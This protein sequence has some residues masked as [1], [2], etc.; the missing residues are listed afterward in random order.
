MRNEKVLQRATLVGPL[1]RQLASFA[2]AIIC[3]CGG[4]AFT[5]LGERDPLSTF[6][7]KEKSS[8]VERLADGRGLEDASKWEAAA[9]HYKGVVEDFADDYHAYHRLGVVCDKLRKHG[10]AQEWYAQALRR[11]PQ[12]AEILND[13]GYSY[14]LSG[15]LNKAESAANKAVALESTNSRFRNNLGLI[16]GQSGRLDEAL[17]HFRVAGSEADAHFNLAFI[18]ASNER[19]EEAKKEFRQALALD[20]S[21]E[22]A[23]NAL[24]SFERSEEDPEGWDAPGDLVVDGKRWVPFVEGAAQGSAFQSQAASAALSKPESGATRLSSLQPASRGFNQASYP[25]TMEG[26]SPNSYQE[27]LVGQ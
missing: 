4:C 20:P 8:L 27:G 25:S 2:L 12:N 14:Y 3:L 23:R 6:S 7:D 22:K 21:H 1:V 10:E 17:S 5:R 16:V 9:K 24:A 11:K 19:P 15:Q 13:L 26:I 18:H